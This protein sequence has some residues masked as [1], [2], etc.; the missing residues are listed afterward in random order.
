MKILKNNIKK[1][2]SIY[3]RKAS[4]EDINT[5]FEKITGQIPKNQEYAISLIS[6]NI[7]EVY[8]SILK[9]QQQENKT[10]FEEIKNNYNN[11][12]RENKKL[13]DLQ[14]AVFKAIDHGSLPRYLQGA[15][16]PRSGHHLVEKILFLDE[17]FWYCE[18]YTPHTCCGSFPCLK[19]LLNNK[20]SGG[21][22]AARSAKTAKIIYVKSH[23]HDLEDINFT[24]RQAIKTLVQYRNPIASIISNYE[25]GIFECNSEALESKG[26]KRSN[27]K[28]ALSFLE[29][30]KA[31]H[32]EK[33]LFESWL[34]NQ[35]HYQINFFHKWFNSSSTQDSSF[36][37]LSYEDLI[38]S[39]GKAY[40]SICNL[41]QLEPLTNLNF[42]LVL[43]RKPLFE[44]END[45][46]N[47]FLQENKGRFQSA[48]AK[49]IKEANLDYDPYYE[50][51]Y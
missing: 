28:D 7:E 20:I 5:A 15:S 11:L 51:S 35:I 43:E 29:D 36:L 22:W 2:C 45:W 24:N 49:I 16:I 12:Q 41:F 25:L 23:D 19:P 9:R 50:Y 34:Q 27:L 42:P 17:R 44:K 8:A 33:T 39:P 47:Q 10:T 14:N 3:G 48:A 4:I 21:Q 1:I 32:M 38:Q 40:D 6:K 30:S 18:H 46:L 13:N 37:K 31:Q 26:I